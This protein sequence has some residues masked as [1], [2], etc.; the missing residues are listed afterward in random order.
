MK[1]WAIVAL[2]LLAAAP[3]A[4]FVPCHPVGGLTIGQ[5]FGVCG[6]ALQ[7]NYREGYGQ[8]ASW[9]DYVRAAYGAYAQ[10]APAPAPGPMGG[11]MPNAGMLCSPGAVQCFNHWVRTCQRMAT[12]G[13][14][15]MTSANRCD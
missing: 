4:A 10:S 7:E 3:A 2:F 15:W 13:S 11:G 8:G 5:W 12:G 1:R 6:P 9:D 14:W